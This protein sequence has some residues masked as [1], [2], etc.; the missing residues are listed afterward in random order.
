[1]EELEAQTTARALLALP[2]AALAWQGDGRPMISRIGVVML[3]GALHALVSDLSPHT[4]AMRAHPAVSLLMGSDAAKGD[5]L[6]HPR[7]A[8]EAVA[9]FADKGELRDRYIAAR[10]KTKLYFDFSDFH[11]V[12]FGVEAAFLNGG[13]GK[14]HHLDWGAIS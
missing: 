7:L 5:P 6:N 11:V 12:R 2:T 3:D 4:A 14:A 13:F 1:M 9:Q 8:L 10:P